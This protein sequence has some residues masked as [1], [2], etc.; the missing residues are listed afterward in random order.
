[1]RHNQAERNA[2]MP[3]LKQN[4]SGCFRTPR[5]AEHFATIPSD[6]ST[7]PKQ[8]PNLFQALVPTVQGT[9]PLTRLG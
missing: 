3:K 2:R 4:V 5:G 9:P 8:S 7:L 6:P 1:M